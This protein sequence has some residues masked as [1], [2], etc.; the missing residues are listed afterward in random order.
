MSGEAGGAQD[1]VLPVECPAWG[2]VRASPSKALAVCMWGGRSRP[3]LFCSSNP[4]QL[5]HAALLV[6][7]QL[8]FA[9]LKGFKDWQN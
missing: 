5:G 6:Y 8:M 1:V 9:C 7:R 2:Q 3:Q 4:F